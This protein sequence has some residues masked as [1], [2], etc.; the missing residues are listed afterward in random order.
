[1]QLF[2]PSVITIVIAAVLAFLVIPRI[3]A[4]ILASVSL[5]ALIAVGFHHYHMFYSEYRLST[6]QNGIGENAPFFVLGFAILFI[7]ASIL[8]MFQG[9]GQAQEALAAPLENISEAVENVVANTK[10][11]NAN[12]IAAGLMNQGANVVNAAKT[13]FAAALPTLN[14]AN[15]AKLA[16]GNANAAK[17]NAA[18]QSPVIPGLGFRASEV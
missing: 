14:S 17:P 18:K 11:S 13:L 1:M 4:L 16:N 7:I 8:F 2:I 10:P 3:G 12:G 5:L 9:G 6:W 15:A